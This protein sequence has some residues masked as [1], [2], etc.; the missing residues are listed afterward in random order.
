MSDFLGKARDFADKHDEQVDK[1]VDRAGDMVDQKTGNK[2]SDH[3][4]RGVD[5][6]QER[7]GAGDTSQ[8]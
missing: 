8:A 5:Q 2:Y 7:T 3:V 4:D 6:V 1:G